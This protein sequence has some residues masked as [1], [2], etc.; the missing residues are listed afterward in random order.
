MQ[1]PRTGSARACDGLNG[2]SAS[3]GEVRD[4]L[5]L[6]CAKGCNGAICARRRSGRSRSGSMVA[7]RP[8]ASRKTPPPI[9]VGLD[10][11]ARLPFVPSPEADVATANPNGT[12][13]THSIRDPHSAPFLRQCLMRPKV[14]KPYADHNPVTEVA[15]AYGRALWARRRLPPGDLI[16]IVDLERRNRTVLMD[17]ASQYGPVFK[18]I[19]HRRLVVCVFGHSLG[20]RVLKEHAKSLRPLSIEL[21]SLFPIGFMRGMEGETHR[22]YRRALVQAISVADLG[23][24][25]GKFEE[26]AAAA[27][28]A[29]AANPIQGSSAHAW[30]DV[31]EQITTSCLIVLVFGVSPGSAVHARLVAAYHDLG[32]HG[33]VWNITDQQATAFRVL[34][35]E[36]AALRPDAGGLLGQMSAQGPVD[37]TM[38][39]NLIY[40]VELGRY[41]LRGLLRWISRYAADNAEWLDRIAAETP[42][43]GS[44]MTS[45]EAFVLETLRMEQS[46]RLMRDVKGDFVFD[47][48]LIPK[49]ALLR[50]CMWEA[51]KDPDTFPRPFVFDPT[52][53][54]GNAPPTDRFSPFGLDHHHCPLAGLSIQMSMAFLRALAEGYDVRGHGAEPAMRGPYHW[55]PSSK[56][57]VGL[58][59]RRGSEGK[60]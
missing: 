34:A 35:A 51:H 17:F 2:C 13:G 47:G 36:L 54:L 33:V 7:E 8:V 27:L 5:L 21:E 25:A 4:R 39:G 16:D 40:M 24:L 6:Q 45:A 10:T 23:A 9:A 28:G 43:P 19:M 55:E 57:T 37:E 48:W 20:R 30:A 14:A 29:Y 1:P 12:L 22:K 53:F 32:P 49:G 42:T 46:E 26:I 44:G 38:L 3:F 15:Q 18:A 31:L 41:D 11:R 58:G 56:F 60:K 59:C 52:R 50:V